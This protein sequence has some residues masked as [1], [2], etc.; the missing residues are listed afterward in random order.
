MNIEHLIGKAEQHDIELFLEN[1]KLG[2]RAYQ[3][4][5]NKGVLQQLSEHK[6]AILHYLQQQAARMTDYSQPIPVSTSQQRIWTIDQLENGSTEFHIP[7]AL[8]LSR[9][10]DLTLLMQRLKAMVTRHYVLRCVF[11]EQDGKLYQRIESA[12]KLQVA[13]EDY[14]HLSHSEAIALA[15]HRISADNQLK[16]DLSQHLPLRAVFF[17]LA[18]QHA[19]VYLN[20]H[21]IAV[22][23]STVSQL[24]NELLGDG[25]QPQQTAAKVQY[26]DYVYWQQTHLRSYA[27]KQHLAAYAEQLADAPALHSLPLDQPYRPDTSNAAAQYKVSLE[28]ALTEAAFK[29]CQQQQLTPFMLFQGALSAFLSVWSNSDDIVLGTP[30]ILRPQDKFNQVIGCFLNLSVLRSQFSAGMTCLDVM[31][32]ARKLSLNLLDWQTVPFEALLDKLKPERSPLYS[33]LFQILFSMHMLEQESS[34]NSAGT[35]APL[36]VARHNTKYDMTVHANVSKQHISFSFEYKTDLFYHSSMEQLAQAFCQFLHTFILSPATLLTHISLVTAQDLQRQQQFNATASS[37]PQQ[38]RLDQLITQQAAATP[39][40]IAIEAEQSLTYRQLEQYSQRMAAALA[41]KGVKAGD[42]V[43]LMLDRSA[44]MVCTMLALMKLEAAYVPLDPSY[45]AQRLHYIFQRSQCQL[46]ISD[47]ADAAALVGAAVSLS[48]DTL[49]HTEQTAGLP[50]TSLGSAAPAYL[51]FTSGSTG[52]P[53]G[54]E[55]SHRN[56]VNFLHSMQ[57]QPGIT[58]RD[59]LLAVTAIS[60]DISVLELFLPLLSGACLVIAAQEQRDGF[61]LRQRLEQGDITLMQ[62]TPAGWQSVLDA[63][64]AGHSGL[65]A[66]TGGEALPAGLAA[67]LQQKTAALWNMYGPTETTVWS[68]VAALN[69]TDPDKI[70]I[71]KPIANTGVFIVSPSHQ[72]CAVG[73]TG[74]IAITGDGVSAGYY[75]QLELTQSRFITLMTAEGEKRAYL[76]GDLGRLTLDGQLQCLGRNDDQ[77][78]LRGFRIELAEIDAALLRLSGVKQAATVVHKHSTGSSLISYYCLQQ[79]GLMYSEQ[80]LQL[81]LKQQLPAYMVPDRIIAMTNM[82][83]TPSGKIDRKAL[84]ALT[85][86]SRQ[87]AH[88]PAQTDLQHQL[89]GLWQQ[90]TGQ[91][92]I[93]ITDNF[94]ALGGDSISSVKVVRFLRDQGYD[95][96]NKL[97]FSYQT[98]EEL[99]SHLPQL[100]APKTDNVTEMQIDGI[101]M[102]LP[103]GAENDDLAAILREFSTH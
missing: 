63:G 88:V 28:P 68:C 50:V 34:S 77:V 76:T 10:V 47:S 15:Q 20:L 83:L 64:W 44:L 52:Q 70:T 13:V 94:F 62:A 31:Q 101:D 71:G 3:P 74:E 86:E 48:P 90:L 96:N 19:V 100:I 38:L 29:L 89:V 30:S 95:M 99:T 57:Q 22:D 98:I 78:K 67:S 24:L 43:G 37:Y 61:S 18:Q 32:Q 60:F 5:P 17:R 72:I 11:T 51:I 1:G 26:A 49:L 35:A 36:S 33:P 97:L 85:V 45:P 2:Y 92:E 25:T 58:S 55:I 87:T 65:T 41:Q 27:F 79:S 23:E 21:H 80:Q 7:V 46:L 12:D 84:A 69:N 102:L 91:P 56:V 53:K 81:Q 14:A 39:D 9:P 42:H 8:I 82:P 75:G 4:Q 54:I 40:N 103:D 16:F 66:L 6:D 93:G 59:K 73:Q